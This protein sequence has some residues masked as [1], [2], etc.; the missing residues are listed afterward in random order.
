MP[1]LSK[2]LGPFL[3]IGTCSHH[4]A[5][6]SASNKHLA[7]KPN[8]HFL[9]VDLLERFLEILRPMGAK[10][11]AVMFQFEYLNREKMPSMQAFIDKLGE[12]FSRAPDGFE[13]AVATKDAR[14]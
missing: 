13:Y 6:Q 3:R 8:A 11:G 14:S 10:L 5:K 1:K 12:F 7:N 9:D 2:E 4:Y